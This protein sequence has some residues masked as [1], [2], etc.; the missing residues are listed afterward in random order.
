MKLGFFFIVPAR[1]C[2]S[3]TTTVRIEEP[4]GPRCDHIEALQ[5]PD[6]PARTAS[7]TTVS[8][9]FLIQYLSLLLARSVPFDIC[10][11]QGFQSCSITVRGAFISSASTGEELLLTFS[12][13][14]TEGGVS[15]FG[16]G[17]HCREKVCGYEYSFYSSLLYLPSLVGWT[18]V[19]L[20]DYRGQLRPTKWHA[21]AS[22]ASPRRAARTYPG[23]R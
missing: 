18:S 21:I 16:G 17:F 2:R 23:H 3:S 13:K 12:Q 6:G 4:F 9:S 5:A 7:Q 10:I 22:M 14:S 15:S 8:V 19:M 11:W 20:S 1:L